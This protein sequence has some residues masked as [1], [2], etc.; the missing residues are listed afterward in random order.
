VRQ[1]NNRLNK[2]IVARQKMVSSFTASNNE[3]YWAVNLI[4]KKENIR[5]FGSYFP[6]H[7]TYAGRRSP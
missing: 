7:T 2:S 5:C 1:R 3:I 6:E 4:S